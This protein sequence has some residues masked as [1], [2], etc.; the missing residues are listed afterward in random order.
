MS[1]QELN[2]GNK[3]IL[4]GVAITVLLVIVSIA[5]SFVLWFRLR[6]VTESQFDSLKDLVKTIS[7]IYIIMVI[8][9]IGEYI[10]FN[11]QE[12]WIQPTL[13]SSFKPFTSGPLWMFVL[14]FLVWIILMVSSFVVKTGGTTNVQKIEKQLE[15][16]DEAKKSEYKKTLNMF[17]AWNGVSYAFAIIVV[18]L[19]VVGGV[20]IA[21]SL[22]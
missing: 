4:A 22:G 2:L 18:L 19:L 14:L 1:D 13:E 17:T 5:L 8:L 6:N 7:T 10:R 21:G 12:G 9:Y 20:S 3:L 15:S 11:W 16:L